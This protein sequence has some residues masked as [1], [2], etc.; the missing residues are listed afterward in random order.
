[1]IDAID[2]DMHARP[3][4]AELIPWLLDV[5]CTPKHVATEFR[6]IMRDTPPLI[7]LCHVQL[8][9]TAYTQPLDRAYTRAFK[10]SIRS[11]VA[12]HFAEFFLWCL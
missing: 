10:S 5:D 9:F 6:S 1:M 2:A 4:D 8:N 12:K 3:D 7:K 11:E